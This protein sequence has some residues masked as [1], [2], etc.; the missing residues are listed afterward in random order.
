[1][2]ILFY[3]DP[4]NAEC[5]L[6]HHLRNIGVQFHNDI[7]QPYDLIFYWSYHKEVREHDAWLTEQHAKQA[8]INYGC[9]DIRKTRLHE[10]FETGLIID[11]ATYKGMAVEKGNGQCSKDERLVECPMPPRADR[12][13][14]RYIDTFKQDEYN[15]YYIDYRLFYFGCISFVCRKKRYT[16][17]FDRKNYEWE[18]I[19][20][21]FIPTNIINYIENKCRLFGFDCG[22]IDLLQDTD[23]RYYVIDLNNVS[24]IA[25][26]WNQ[27]QQYDIRRYYEDALDNWLRI[28]SR[29]P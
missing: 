26:N 13:Y 16:T 23:G 10:V 17:I 14:L 12:I 9:N 29:L 21:F 18:A 24:G 5:K 19:P 4:I 6:Y 28:I 7:S 2:T 11:P 8:V 1:M 25:Y 27:P 20:K 3:P 22:E 15:S